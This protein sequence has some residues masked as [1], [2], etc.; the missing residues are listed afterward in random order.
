MLTATVTPDTNSVFSHWEGNCSGSST[1]STANIT[2]NNSQ[3]FTA[4][5]DKTHYQ[6]SVAGLN[7]AIVSAP[8]EPIDC[9]SDCSELYPVSEGAQIVTLTASAN[10]GSVF[11]RWYGSPDCY[12]E[13]ENDSNLKTARVTVGTTDVNCR[14]MSVLENTEFA[15][16]VEKSGGSMSIFSLLLLI[17][18]FF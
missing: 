2:M 18:M 16:T 3:S 7:S 11:V 9:G 8:I 10:P 12:D 6:L 5:F 4:V 17:L 14:A 13:D 15:L 1:L